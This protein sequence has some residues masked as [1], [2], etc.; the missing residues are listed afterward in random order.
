M[1]K[2]NSGSF[3][4]KEHSVRATPDSIYISTLYSN[5]HN[6]HNKFQEIEALAETWFDTSDKDFIVENTLTKLQRNHRDAGSYLL[7]TT[8]VYKH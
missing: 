2:R 8:T 5:M 1:V 4:I 6:L 3:I 7:T